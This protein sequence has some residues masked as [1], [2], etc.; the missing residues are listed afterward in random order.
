MLMESLKYHYKL[1][2]RQERMVDPE[3]EANVRP[4]FQDG[5]RIKILPEP[6]GTFVVIIPSPRSIPN[7]S[8]GASWSTWQCACSMDPT[9]RPNSN[10]AEFCAS[11]VSKLQL[12]Y[13]FR[14]NLTWLDIHPGPSPYPLWKRKGCYKYASPLDLVT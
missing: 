14:I 2:K 8:R 4:Q 7:P 1:Y 10:S 13:G 6:P 12:L 11:V 5:L 3:I 9:V